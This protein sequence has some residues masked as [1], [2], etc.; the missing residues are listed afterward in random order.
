[1]SRVEEH[2]LADAVAGVLLTPGRRVL[3]PREL[4]QRPG[5]RDLRVRPAATRRLDFGPGDRL[6]RLI[7]RTVIGPADGGDAPT[8]AEVVACGR[9]AEKSVEPDELPFRSE[10]AEHQMRAQELGQGELRCAR[11]GEPVA[12]AISSWQT[13]IASSRSPDR[14]RP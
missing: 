7:E 11:P 6:G 8:A 14:N 9:V 13:V 2:G 1:M 10:I 4:G 3:E 5:R 12:S